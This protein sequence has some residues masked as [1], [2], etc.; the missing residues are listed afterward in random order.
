MVQEFSNLNRM[1]RLYCRE[2][3]INIKFLESVSTV[4]RDGVRK[5][6]YGLKILENIVGDADLDL[7]KLRTISRKIIEAC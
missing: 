6:L 7:L 2:T 3:R 5:L 1:S 4:D